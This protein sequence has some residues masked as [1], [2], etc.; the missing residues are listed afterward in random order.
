MTSKALR[1][2]DAYLEK[3]TRLPAPP[4]VSLIT[5]ET[6]QRVAVPSTSSDGSFEDI[7]RCISRLKTL[8]KERERRFR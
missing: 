5:K 8:R 2:I 3:Q 4:A 1:K 6:A 7:D